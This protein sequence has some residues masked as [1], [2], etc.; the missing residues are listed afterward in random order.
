MGKKLGYV[1]SLVLS[2]YIDCKKR[3]KK[4]IEFRNEH[5]YLKADEEMIRFML[6]NS[7]I[8]DHHTD[9]AFDEVKNAVML[10]CRKLCPGQWCNRSHCQ[11][12]RSGS[13][14]NCSKGTRPSVCKDYKRWQE[15]KKAREEINK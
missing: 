10:F 7:S 5:D 8:T 15:K 11:Y 3:T 6:E 9:N 1:Q 13:A 12:C 14:Y 4:D 2:T